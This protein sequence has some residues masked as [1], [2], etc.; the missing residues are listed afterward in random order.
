MDDTWNESKARY[1]YRPYHHPIAPLIDENTLRKEI[2]IY[3]HLY[4]DI[5]GN[6]NISVGFFP[7]EL[8]FQQELLKYSLKKELTGFYVANNHIS[9]SVENFP[10]NFGSHGEMR[11]SQSC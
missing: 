3:K 4:P 8:S 10:I 6:E 9:R 5:W 7:P 2:Q 1:C 11:S